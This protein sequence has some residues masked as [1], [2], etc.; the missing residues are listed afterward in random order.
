VERKLFGSEKVQ[1]DTEMAA[2][3]QRMRTPDGTGA[4]R[5]AKE[6]EW[7]QGV[8]GD[9]NEKSG[10]RTAQM[11]RLPLVGDHRLRWHEQ[12]AFL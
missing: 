5:S 9:G 8:F 1:F 11:R 12:K 4:V 10:E 6:C 7:K 2:P 3:V